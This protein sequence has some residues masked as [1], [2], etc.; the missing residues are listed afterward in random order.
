MKTIYCFFQFCYSSEALLICFFLLLCHKI[1]CSLDKS[2]SKGCLELKFVMMEKCHEW[3]RVASFYIVI[4]LPQGPFLGGSQLVFIK[5]SV[6]S[7]LFGK[8]LVAVTKIGF[9]C[10]LKKF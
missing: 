8:F 3:R 7:T 2:K 5:A 6:N 9:D 4:V 10:S 1:N